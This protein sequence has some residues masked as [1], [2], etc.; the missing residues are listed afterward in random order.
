MATIFTS[1]SFEDSPIAK[2]L[3]VQLLSKEHRTK[4]P[5]G[6]PNV[7]NQRAN[8][9]QAI[10]ESRALIAILSKSENFAVTS[11]SSD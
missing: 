4:L 5:I 7:G 9:T 8:I 6:R 1:S 10:R 11:V 2:A 3:E